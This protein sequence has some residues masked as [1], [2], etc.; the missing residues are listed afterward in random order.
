MF[1]DRVPRWRFVTAG[2]QAFRIPCTEL[3]APFCC[4]IDMAGTFPRCLTCLL[5]LAKHMPFELNWYRSFSNRLHPTFLTRRSYQDLLQHRPPAIQIDSGKKDIPQSSAPNGLRDATHQTTGWVLR[6]R[7]TGANMYP[8][9]TGEHHMHTMHA[10]P[11]HRYRRN[12]ENVRER[13]DTV[14]IIKDTAT[15][16]KLR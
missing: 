10:T 12:P 3:C 8:A 5:D 1:P 15:G 7:P 6:G 16:W 2:L 4:N 11:S 9:R 14:T 13:R